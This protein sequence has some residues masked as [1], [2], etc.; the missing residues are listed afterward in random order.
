MTYHTINPEQ[1]RASVMMQ[2]GFFDLEF[3]NKKLY[4]NRDPLVKINKVVP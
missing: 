4:T 1:E 3:Q 2:P